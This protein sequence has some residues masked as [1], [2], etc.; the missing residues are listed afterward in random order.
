ML[1][2]DVRPNS[3][4]FFCSRIV[5]LSLSL[6]LARSLS[7]SLFLSLALSS[8]LSCAFLFRKTC[9]PA[10]KVYQLGSGLAI[11]ASYSNHLGCSRFV[12]LLQYCGNQI[13]T[14]KAKKIVGP[15]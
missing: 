2:I 10:D 13:A 9:G 7:L 5:S 15:M 14:T 1:L 6:S 12:S 3:Q 11:Q 4:T 8:L